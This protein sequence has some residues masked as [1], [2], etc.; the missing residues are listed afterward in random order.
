[1]TRQKVDSVLR[2][3]NAGGPFRSMV[4]LVECDGGS[5]VCKSGAA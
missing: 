2:R 1:M 4:T 3:S 5:G